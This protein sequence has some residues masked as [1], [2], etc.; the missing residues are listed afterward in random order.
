[1]FLSLQ[2]KNDI[3]LMI[4]IWIILIRVLCHRLF[5]IVVSI[6]WVREVVLLAIHI[7]RKWK[8]AWHSK[9]ILFLLQILVFFGNFLFLT[10]FYLMI[11]IFSFS[12]WTFVLIFLRSFIFFKNIFDC[13]KFLEILNIF[14]NI[15]LILLLKDLKIIE[16]LIL[17]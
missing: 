16:S 4:F 10:L 14:I 6:I 9:I 2:K 17:K 1:M 3:F 5:R 15:F 12:I 13:A 8:N 7:A 11:W